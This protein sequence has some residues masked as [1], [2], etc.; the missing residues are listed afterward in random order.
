MKREIH[1][2]RNGITY[3]YK[4]FSDDDVEL[5]RKA[6][7]KLLVIK[8]RSYDMSVNSEKDFKE[9][10]YTEKNIDVLIKNV[11][12]FFGIVVILK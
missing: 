8:R 12:E 6:I 7:K 2:Y 5:I 1:L 3:I 9:K 10:F 11:F 4:I